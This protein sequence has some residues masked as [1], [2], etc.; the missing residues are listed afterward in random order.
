[1]KSWIR[2]LVIVL[3]L[4]AAGASAETMRIPLQSLTPLKAIELRCTSDEREVQLPVPDRWDL[5][6]VVLHLRYTVSTNLL[7]DVSQLVVKV[8]GQPVAQARLNPLAP[9]VKLG[10]EIPPRLFEPGYNAVAFNVA[11]HWSRQQCEAPCAPDLWTNIDLRDSYVE[12]EYGLK[13]LPRELSVLS[14]H[15]FDPRLMPA[16]EV[17]IVT[18][19]L[20]AGS[21]T[22]AGIVSSGIARRFDYRRVGFSVSRELRPGMDN[23]VVGKRAFVNRL[24]A[25]RGVSLAAT[26]GGYLK[27]LPM[28]AAG[29]GEDPTRALLVISGEDENAAR[30]AAITFSNISFRFPGADEMKAFAFEMPDVQQYSGRE[31][32]ATDT[33]YQFKTLNFPTQSFVGIN[34]GQRSIS[35]RL[36]PDFHIRPNQ[37]A[38]LSLSFSYGAG[39]KN[40]SSMNVSVNGRGMRAVLLDSPSGSFIDGYK[41][42]I[43]TYVFQPGTNTIS[44]SGHL[45]AG[46]Q[47]CDLIMADN[48]FLTVYDVSTLTFPAMPHLVEMPK[49]EL[50]VHS[51]FPL[52]R[53]P[54]GH[55]S[56]I[57]LTE[58]DDNV[59][60]AALNLVGLAT[61]R[62][63][64]PL[65][66]LTFTYD[67][68]RTEGEVLIIGRPQSL[69][70]ELRAAAPLKMLDDGVTVPYPVVRGW[71]NEA[72][73]AVSKQQSALGPGRGLLMQ[74]Q[75]PF[76]AG[77]TV[78]MLTASKTEDLFNASQ[79]LLTTA[80]Q[81][82]SRGDVVLI[83][84]GQPEAKV[85]SMES[86]V[87]YV[88][89]RRGSFS[90]VES[91]FYTRPI[92]YYAVIAVVLLLLSAGLFVAMRRWRS[93]RK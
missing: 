77:R 13:P 35:F 7:P 24:L 86:G 82:Q 42:D 79:A 4:A 16:G 22:L 8:R 52:T 53:W 87:R 6:R 78:V 76:Q 19:D 89:G 72:V 21:A 26:Q 61:Q 37:Y 12:M 75:S 88:T 27:L 84:P 85:T 40:D 57:W 20:S 49:L 44:L 69:P 2:C 15:V 33:V 74:F 58:K 1:M 62:N 60:G 67:A 41:I 65:F 55:E 10:I 68:P 66:G 92:V 34:P 43:P 50:F 31:T 14:T 29:G 63:G 30:L 18:E 9:D 11:Q 93:K 91:F 36:P 48:L 59:L 46:G 3:G 28:T 51:G 73:A 71:N 54:D 39:L 25:S 81:S 23:V 47:L 64:F 45:H 90:R 56:Y 17:H 32:I 5:K 38:K 83:E 70:R 80:A